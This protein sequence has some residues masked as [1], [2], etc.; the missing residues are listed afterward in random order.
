MEVGSQIA[1]DKAH[2]EFV[3]PQGEADADPSSHTI[4]LSIIV[5]VTRRCPLKCVFCSESE[6]MPDPSFEALE[7]IA[8]KLSGVHRVYLSGGE[9][10]LRPDIFDLIDVY[11]RQ[12]PVVGLPTNC[13]FIDRTVAERLRGRIS[14]VNAGLDG[15][16]AVNARLRGSYDEII[17]GLTHLRDAGI[18]VSLSTVIL[19]ETL[20][21][22]QYV[23]AVADALGI[24]KVKFVIPVPRGRA[25]ALT[26]D[27]YANASDILAEFQRLTDL[28]RQAGWRPRLK[29]T[30]W[31]ESTEG[32]AL[33]VYPDQTVVAWP[34]LSAE[35]SIFRVG[36]LGTDSLQD[37]WRRYPYKRNHL[38]KYTGLA[39]HKA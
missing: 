3:A 26:D 34:V 22:L 4:P 32:Y 14:Y 6:Q 7:S 25:T 12:F 37:I 11:R 2:H 21:Y 30:F 13:V 9:P 8:S 19:R 16:P 24:I 20:P 27:D 39:M 18:E 33:L 23:V 38:R 1:F 31:D 10:L 36:N 15:P 5:Q 17:K 29:F 35:Q 28:K